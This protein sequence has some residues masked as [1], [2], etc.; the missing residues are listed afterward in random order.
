MLRG[1]GWAGWKTEVSRVSE[2]GAL[3]VSSFVL[4]LLGWIRGS[5]GYESLA[6]SGT[7][8]DP[9]LGFF[10]QVKQMC[11]FFQD[12]RGVGLGLQ[13]GLEMYDKRS[14]ILSFRR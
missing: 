9:R 3:L 12:T 6:M 11:V 7:C 13:V 1:A 2:L 5:T 4:F 10:I 8:H 14:V